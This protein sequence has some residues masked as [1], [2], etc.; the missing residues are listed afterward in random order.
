MQ[1]NLRIARF[2]RAQEIFVVADLQ[3]WVQAALQQD[4]RAA[5]LEHLVDFLV[6]LLEGKDVAVLRTERAVERA[7][8]TIFSAEIRVIDVA[9]DLV[10]DDARIVFLEA[11]LVGFHAH[12]HE[13]VGFEHLE[14]LLFGQWQSASLFGPPQKAV[15]TTSQPPTSQRPSESRLLAG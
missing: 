6:N 8:G 11:K 4:S 9:V 12:A 10:S 1:M 3:I 5:E 14:R 13:I 2:Q 15:P 7:E